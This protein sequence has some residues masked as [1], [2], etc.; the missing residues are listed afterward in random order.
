MSL[1]TAVTILFFSLI[2]TLVMLVAIGANE[3]DNIRKQN[4]TECLEQVPNAQWCYD[5]FVE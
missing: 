4:F 2:A 5:K 1:E 3:S